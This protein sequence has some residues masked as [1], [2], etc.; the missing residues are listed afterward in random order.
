[1]FTT[2]HVA[3]TNSDTGLGP[4]VCIELD[5]SDD[6]RNVVS[7][8]IQR[9][10]LDAYGARIP[11]PPPR[12][13]AHFDNQG[14]LKCAA[15]LLSANEGFFSEAYLDGPIEAALRG[16]GE[17]DADRLRIGEI[18]NLVSDDPRCT[19]GF[20][21]SIADHARGAGFHWLFF[22]LTRRL[23]AYLMR[24]GARLQPLAPALPQRIETAILW[25]DYYRHDPCVYA[26][27]LTYRTPRASFSPRAA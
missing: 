10:Y 23:S 9:A 5:A 12:L 22:T 24:H 14:A 6:R 16:L 4:A 27:Q 19:E 17:T 21:A 1:M 15:G 2:L 20:I 7:A 18:C 13:L 11:D 8:F 26:V 25:G 3:P